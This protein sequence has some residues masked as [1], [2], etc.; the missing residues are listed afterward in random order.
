MNR[1]RRCYL[2]QRAAFAS[3]LR[4]LCTDTREGPP[5]GDALLFL[6]IH[7]HDIMVHSARRIGLRGADRIIFKGGGVSYFFSSTHVNEIME[8]WCCRRAF[9]LEERLASGRRQDGP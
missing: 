4:R 3:Q 9:E 1:L 5:F 2:W 7:G 8:Q 6:E